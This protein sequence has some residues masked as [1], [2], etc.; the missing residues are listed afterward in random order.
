MTDPDQFLFQ[1]LCALLFFAHGD[2]QKII[3][4]ANHFSQEAISVYIDEVSKAL[5]HPEILKIYIRFPTTRQER[6]RIKQR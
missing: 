1:V 3:G 6:D 2:Y 5:N 4:E